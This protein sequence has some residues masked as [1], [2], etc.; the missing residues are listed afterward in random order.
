MAENKGD[1]GSAAKFAQARK[2]TQT[3][4]GTLD[5]A[6]HDDN[7]AEDRGS[8]TSQST[9]QQSPAAVV[10]RKQRYLIG[11]RALPGLAP[12]HLDPFLDR[13]SHMEGVEIVRRLRGNGPPIA[14]SEVVVARMDEQRGEALRLNA[15]PHVIIERDTP[16]GYSHMAVPELMGWQP[17]ARAMPYPRPRRELRVRVL[18]EADRPIPNAVVNLYGPGFPA[19]AI[20]DPSGQAS[21]QTDAVDGGGMV[22]IH[23]RPAADYWERYIHSPS[24]ELG[25]TNVVRLNPLER[26][27]ARFPG[28]RPY[29]W[30]QRIMRFDRAP[31]E[32]TGAGAKI[33]I[34]D[35]GCDNSHPQLRHIVQGTD[36][37]R[38]RDAQGTRDQDTRGWRVDELAHGTHCAGTIAA[39]AGPSQAIIGCAPAA[40]VHVFKVVPGGHSSDLVEALDQCIARDLDIV[41]IGVS[42]DQFSELV[43]QK[44]T[45]ARLH[46]VAC[47]AAAGN[48]GGAVQFPGNVPGV[49]TVSAVGKLGE[50][51]EDTRHAQRTLPQLIGP[52]G[53]YATNFSCWGPQIGVC[54]PGVAIISSVPGGGYAAWDGSSM[55]A[56]HVVGL[57]ALLLAHHPML[58]GINYGGRA[59]QRVS[60]LFDMLR[61]AGMPYAQ[62]DPNR[63]GAG[64]PDLQQLPGLSST[65]PL[66]ANQQFYGSVVMQPALTPPAAFLANSM[67]NAILQLRAAGLW[68]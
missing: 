14:Q 23:V 59:E 19:Q 8:S 32:W 61:V 55:A 5:A 52:S 38:E 34:I 43:A 33:G 50:Y 2:A 11:F 26:T 31:A 63:V 45:E 37:T 30:G 16:L 68:V 67:N 57:G 25:Q 39:A 20:T 47:V 48:S 1:P 62:V 58:Q 13:L 46:G 4:G 9:A 28:E 24:L 7:A 15:P 22:A 6:T 54:A 49:L 51:P 40:E 12:P 18:G 44:I 10:R 3:P 53:I 17:A 42:S 21:L 35:S 60:V 29:G 65:N 66:L 36:L 41:Q 64:L 27:A 56:A